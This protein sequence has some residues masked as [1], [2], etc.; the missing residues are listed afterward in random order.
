M[1]VITYFHIGINSVPKSVIR[2]SSFG[3]S[4]ALPLFL[5]GSKS[6]P[7]LNSES[8]GQ[9]WEALCKKIETPQGREKKG[10]FW[11]DERSWF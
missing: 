5:F 9:K 11:C 7:R 1:N 4:R 2:M 3:C 10:K 6:A 8:A